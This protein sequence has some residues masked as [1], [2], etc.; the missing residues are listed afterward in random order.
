MKVEKIE[1]EQQLE[2]VKGAVSKALAIADEI[3][4]SEAECSISK[5]SGISVGTRMG[6]VETVEFNQ[7]GALGISVYRDHR[8]GS[9]STTDLSPE[10][11][12]AAVNKACEIAKHTSADPYNGLADKQLIAESYPELDLCHPGDQSA[13][14]AIEQ[15]LRCERHA[16]QLDKRI[17]NSD[18]A[19][20]GSHSGFKVYGNSHGFLGGYL[21][22]RH[23]LSCVLIAEQ[24]GKMQRDMSYTVA[25]EIDDL[26]AAEKV[27]EQAADETL[28]RLGAR[29]ID[30]AKVPVIFRADVA[31]SLFGHLVSAISG[32]N[33]Y[34]KSS[35]LLDALG[36]QVLPDWL[37]VNENPHIIG[38]LASSPFDNEGLPTR[39]QDIVKNG[40]LQTYLLTSYAARKLGRQPTGHA[41]GIH[42]W[43]LTHSDKSLA[44]LCQQM[45]TGLLV[46][47][48]M[49][50][51]VNLVNGDYSRGA[52]GFW[53]ENGEIQY[54]VE[55]ITIAGNL[56]DMLRNIVEIGGDIDARHALHTG[57]VLLDEL[58]VA[59]A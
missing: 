37:T 54:P 5:S 1:L 59:G 45:G 35:F 32:G 15:A 40:E 13:D 57:S 48:L 36:K 33:L 4:V 46:T 31:G 24:D 10:A 53:V 28:S 50:Q 12:R 34:R 11:I 19:H 2:Q 56:K 18:G 58:R 22:S 44:E 43:R 17:I 25:R 38:G 26:V 9:A 16:L 7:D 21:Q 51:G 27:A 6:E 55:E 29:K 52:A 47:E 30:T 23:D 3:G 20:Y 39:Q 41:G 42:N 8:K 14:Y 49:G